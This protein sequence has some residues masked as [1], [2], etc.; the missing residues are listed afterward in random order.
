MTEEGGLSTLCDKDKQM[1]YQELKSIIKEVQDGW[2]IRGKIQ[3]QRRIERKAKLANDDSDSDLN[4][5]K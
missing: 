3:E 4:E 2:E 5:N 1:Y